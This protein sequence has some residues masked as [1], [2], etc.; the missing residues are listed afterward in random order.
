MRKVFNDRRHKWLILNRG[1]M[2]DNSIETLVTLWCKRASTFLSHINESVCY[3]KNDKLNFRSTSMHTQRISVC[4]L[5]WS[6][7]HDNIVTLYTTHPRLLVVSIVTWC[8]LNQCIQYAFSSAIYVDSDITSPVSL[9]TLNDV[10]A[11]HATTSV[12][13]HP[14]LIKPHIVASLSA[15]QLRRMMRDFT[16]RKTL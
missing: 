13:L 8:H 15:F 12:S 3:L 5:H 4:K 10:Q 7:H 6:C 16:P 11:D 9:Y 14:K 2:R 1:S